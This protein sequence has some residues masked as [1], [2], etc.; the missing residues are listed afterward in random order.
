M[1]QE[2]VLLTV[3]GRRNRFRRKNINQLVSLHIISL[4]NSFLVLGAIRMNVLKHKLVSLGDTNQK[5]CFQ[6]KLKIRSPLTSLPTSTSTKIESEKEL[7]E[8]NLLRNSNT[9]PKKKSNTV[10]ST[11]CKYKEI[12]PTNKWYKIWH[13]KVKIKI[14]CNLLQVESTKHL[15]KWCKTF[16]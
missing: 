11:I 3:R 2:I 14:I 15:F 4:R 10:Y 12:W 16:S 6:I 8:Q 7:T 5:F 13:S 1:E 9:L